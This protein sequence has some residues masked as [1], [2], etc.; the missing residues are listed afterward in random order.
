MQQV[1]IYFPKRVIIVFSY[2]QHVKGLE[3]LI[4]LCVQL[5]GG[6]SLVMVGDYI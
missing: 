1:A 6:K 3:C 4:E 2:N 5:G